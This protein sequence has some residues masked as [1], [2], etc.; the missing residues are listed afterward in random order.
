VE[1]ALLYTFSTIPQ[2]LAAALGV[3]AAFVL[4]R[5]QSDSS[6]QWQDA[7]T[8]V[9]QFG[10]DVPTQLIKPQTNLGT[11]LG[12]QRFESLLRELEPR[13]EKGGW[14]ATGS[15]Q[16]LAYLRLKASIAPRR[17]ILTALKWAFWATAAVILLSVLVLCIAHTFSQCTWLGGVVLAIGVC[18]LAWCL[19]LYYGLIRAALWN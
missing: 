12:T 7:Y 13:Y 14:P 16:Y 6:T 19:W 18:S 10:G 17:K 4:Y 2:T 3:L 8:L 1:Y 5:L 11:L 9:S 15:S